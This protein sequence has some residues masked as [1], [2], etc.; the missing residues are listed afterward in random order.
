LQRLK[1]EP[2][3][4]E[5]FD[6]VS[7]E[8]WE[9]K[10][11]ADLKGKPLSDLVWEVE[12]NVKVFPF[13]HADDFENKPS[14]IVGK[15]SS[16]GWG[17]G[18]SFMVSDVKRSNQQ[19]LKALNGGAGAIELRLKQNLSPD[20][21]ASLFSGINPD[22]ISCH[23]IL[24]GDGDLVDFANNWLNFVKSCNLDPKKLKGS[25]EKTDS[26]VTVEHIR[27]IKLC[28]EELSE[29]RV[30]SISGNE[31]L[32]P[33]DELAK[34]IQQAY[35]YIAELSEAGISPATI[36]SKI[37]FKLTVGK[38]FF[39]EIAKI[40]ALKLLWG[41]L[42]KAFGSDP[43]IPVEISVSFAKQALEEDA[44]KNMIAAATMAMSAVIGGASRLFVNPSGHNKEQFSRR[45]AR[46]VQHLL[47]MESF[48]DK[49]EDPG[50]G[51][52]YIEKLT[53][54]LGETAWE[55]VKRSV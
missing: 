15:A 34:S 53:N 32:S 23:F 1:K 9:A 42:L 30:I 43:L 44:N 2:V 3:M 16:T 22:F 4:F 39:V 45:I 18:E 47:K 6:K 31:G 5:D 27:A 11:I 19:I 36:A 14:P 38:S 46:N 10:V 48:L 33:S 51:S 8:A 28:K 55:K 12:N 7:K 29:F 26:P 13:Y 50:A 17:I 54:S 20:D 21:L 37:Q 24:G 49:V 52:Y 35:Q 25:F 41:N 40:R